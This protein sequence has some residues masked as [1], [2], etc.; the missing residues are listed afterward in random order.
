MRAIETSY[1]G[2]RFR[3]RT[4]ARWATFFDAIGIEWQYEKE[5]FELSDG[6]RYLPD[7]WLP[8]RSEVYPDA[9]GIGH[10]VEIKG[11]MPTADEI[12]KM[13]TLVRDTGHTGLIFVGDPGK[14]TEFKFMLQRKTGEV[15]EFECKE[16]SPIDSRPDANYW[17]IKAFR[18]YVN[19][20]VPN[21]GEYHFDSEPLSE[22]MSCV[23]SARS[24]RFEFGAAE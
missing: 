10:W 23:V 17:A 14:Y 19:S 16:R 13:Q 2:Y 3:S 12:R 18:Y 1:K 24:A 22:I 9:S 20:H 5:G 15:V 11:V 6:S 8:I 21:D 7:F 4:E